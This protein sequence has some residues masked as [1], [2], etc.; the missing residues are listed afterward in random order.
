MAWEADKS[1]SVC[2]I[3]CE[4]TYDGINLLKSQIK[5]GTTFENAQIRINVEKSEILNVAAHLGLD[6]LFHA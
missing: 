3:S 5:P 2:C 6:T 1:Q 4:S